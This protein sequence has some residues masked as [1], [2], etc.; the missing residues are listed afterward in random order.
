[1]SKS[2]LLNNQDHQNLR[3][4]PRFGAR[5]GHQV[6]RMV[7]FPNEIQSLHVQYPLLFAHGE[8]GL[9]LVALFGFAPDENLF[10]NGSQWQAHVAPLLASR[11]PF[12]IGFQGNDQGQPSAVVHVDLAD[13]RLSETEGVPLFLEQGGAGP[14]LQ[15]IQGV[16]KAIDEGLKQTAGLVELLQ[17]HE[18][19]EPMSLDVAIGETSYQLEGYLG[20]SA[21][22]LAGLSDEVIGQLN[23]SGALQI[24]HLLHGSLANVSR[25][26][27]LKQRALQN[28]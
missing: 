22:G 23:R 11:G 9:Q 18:L 16:L 14:Q 20:I 17:A 12:M 5:Y 4:Q 25:L 10:L 24:A 13:D 1:M 7:V 8:Q 2:V 19:L 6:G 26:A 21:R 15:R 27:D 28:D 3:Y